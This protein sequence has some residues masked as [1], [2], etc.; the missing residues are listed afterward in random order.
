MVDIQRIAAGIRL[1]AMDVDGVLTAGEIIV[2]ESGEEVKIW[3]VR[4]RMGF[5]LLKLSGA[6]IKV[7]WVTGRSSKQ[8]QA[9]AD[10]S[11]IDALF[12]GCDKKDDALRQ[13]AERFGVSG[14]EIAYIGD[15]VID[16]P[17]M[18]LA[19]LGICPCDA[20]EEVKEY[21]AIITRSA[22]GRGVA[23]EVID[24]VLKAHHVWER[25]AKGYI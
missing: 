14:E 11:G 23:R 10:E 9:R 16:I 3:N 5:H 8:V 18:K 7:A 6:D 20:V 2:L 4:D 13:L 25:A 15:D 24:L 1:I 12:Q 19:G 22:G 21:A 17:A